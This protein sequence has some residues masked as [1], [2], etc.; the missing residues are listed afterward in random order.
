MP[1]GMPLLLIIIVA[2]PVANILHRAGRSR[3]WTILAF[4]PLV[5]LIGLWV[6]AFTRWPNRATTDAC[7]YRANRTLSRHR[8]MTDSDPEPTWAA[9][10]SRS[11]AGLTKDA[12]ADHVCTWQ[13]RTCAPKRCSGSDP[14]RSSNGQC[15]P[16]GEVSA[17][18]WL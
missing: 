10:K 14:N 15:S 9:L 7:S 8:R 4:V 1:L 5:N 11:A 12:F 18:P 16:N 6:F 2:V 17:T 13:S 3:W